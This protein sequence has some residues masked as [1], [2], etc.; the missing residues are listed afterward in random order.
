MGFLD[1]IRPDPSAAKVHDPVCHMTID[2]KSAAGTSQHEG[3][4]VHFCSLSCKK[5]F[6]ADPSKYPLGQA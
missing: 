3:R 6:D 5:R 1:K 2:P 4:T